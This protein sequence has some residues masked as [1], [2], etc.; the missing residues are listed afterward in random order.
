MEIQKIT[1]ETKNLLLVPTTKAYAE[2]MFKNFDEETTKYMFPKS[3]EKIEETMS[4]IDTVL[5]KREEKE[6]L[7]MTIL[8]KKTKEFIGNAW[9]HRIKTKTPELGIWIKKTAYWKKAWREAVWALIDR[10]NENLDFDYFVYPVDQRNIPSK[11]IAEAFWGVAEVD[12]NNQI[13]INSKETLDPNRI[14]QT[15]VYRISKK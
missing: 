2:E 1:L 4:W 10:W 12:E 15:I 6:E 13:I 9:L 14:L 5:K 11:K 8:D 3:P 7:Q